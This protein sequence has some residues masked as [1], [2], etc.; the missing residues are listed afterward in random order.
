MDEITSQLFKEL[1]SVRRKSNAKLRMAARKSKNG[2]TVSFR[3]V[4]AS[5]AP[6]VDSNDLGFLKDRFNMSDATLLKVVRMINTG[7]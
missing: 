2:A 4:S 3:F 7:E 5:N 1:N 6:P